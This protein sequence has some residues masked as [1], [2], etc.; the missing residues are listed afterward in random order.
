MLL[1]KHSPS[2]RIA[3]V[4]LILSNVVA[5]LGPRTHLVAEA[6]VDG[7]HGLLLGL[8]IGLLLLGLRRRTDA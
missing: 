1:R 7:V 5:F 4:F 2:I 8:A 3:L 6:W